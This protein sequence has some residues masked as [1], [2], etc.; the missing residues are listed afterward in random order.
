MEYVLRVRIDDIENWV[1]AVR[2]GDKEIVLNPSVTRGMLVY[3][4]H[5]DPES[6][7]PIMQ[8]LKSMGFEAVLESGN[9]PGWSMTDV[10]TED[11]DY[12]LVGVQ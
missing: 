10:D 5:T 11:F 12:I 1:H 7:K 6:L 8:L 2:L 3:P 4:W 9:L